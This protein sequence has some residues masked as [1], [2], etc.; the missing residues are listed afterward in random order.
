M[1]ACT[2][3]RTLC[4]MRYMPRPEL[5]RT[6]GWE[7]PSLGPMGY[8]IPDAKSFI[9]VLSSRISGDVHRPVVGQRDTPN[10][11]VPHDVLTTKLQTKWISIPLSPLANNRRAR[12]IDKN[13]WP[14]TYFL[15]CSKKGRVEIRKMF[16]RTLA[17][18][19]IIIRPQKVDIKI[20]GILI[21]MRLEIP[22][23]RTTQKFSACTKTLCFSRY[24]FYI[25]N[26]NW[27]M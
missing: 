25:A 6:R 3:V 10:H 27:I 24:F 14:L 2:H 8:I 20:F 18:P 7:I 16:K 9:K 26:R 15:A 1:R 19:G 23:K 21:T 13:W 22:R 11:V 4:R 5:C 17:P 12:R